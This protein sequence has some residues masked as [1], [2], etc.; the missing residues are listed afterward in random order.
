MAK[1]KIIAGLTAF[2]CCAGMAAG[3]PEMSVKTYAS[4]V[5]HNSFESNYDG[6]YG[7]SDTV[8]ITAENG[9]GYK[10]SRGMTVKGRVSAEDG[11]AS[12]KGFYLEGGINYNYS[13]MVYSKKTENFRVSL[14]CIDEK[15][16]KEKN[17][18]LIS[19][20]V[21]AGE[22]TELSTEYT[23][24]KGSY[25][26]KITIT[27]DSTNDFS[28]DDVIITTEKNMN[29][30]Y[31][32]SSEKGLKDEFA[33][34]FRVGN[35][36][37]NMT[38]KNSAIT[39]NIIKD[40][41]SI[42][43]E[44]ETKPDA[45]LVQSQCSG[46]NIGVSLQ[47]AAA[48][49]DFCVQNN[50]A[51]RGHTLVWHSQTPTWFF[52]KDFNANSNW[53]D[54][55]TMDAR[56]ESYIKNMFNA[57]KTQYPD[58]NLYAYDVANE[59]VSDDSRRTANNGG[60]REPGDGKVTGGKSAWVQ[61]YGDNSFVEKAFTYARKYAPEGCALY[62]NDYNEYWDHKR[63]AIYNMCKSLYQKGLLDG[64]GMQ[65]HVPANATGF[66]G[67]DSYIYAMK[68]YLS[69]GCD[70]QITE[71]DISLDKGKYSLQDQANKYKAIFQAAM[72]WNANPQSTGRVTAVCVW[73]PNDAN[74]WLSSGSD[75]LL[76]D[77]NN[78]PKLAYKTLTS[79]IP[80]SEWGEGGSVGG[81][82]EPDEN[83]YYFHSTFE[84]DVDT[85]AGRGNAD[86][87]TSGRTA[88]AGKEALLVE[89]RTSAWNGTTRSLNAR[90]FIPGNEYS[91]SVNVSYFDGEST[92]KF[93]LKLQ[94]ED[95]DGET[96]YSTIAEGTGIAGEW[97]QLANTNYKIPS[98]ASKMQLYVETAETT[99]NFYIDEAIG[100]VAGTVIKGAGQSTDII[101]GDIT[102]DN[103]IDC[104]DIVLAR[105]GLIS[106]FASARQKIAADVDRSGMIEIND[107]LLMRKFVLRQITE[108]PDNTPI[109]NNTA[110]K[111][112][113]A[114]TYSEAP[115]EYMNV[116]SQ[117][118]TIKKETYNG[119][120]GNNNLNVYLPYGYD[121]N[122]Q[123]NIFYLMH[124]GGENENTIF[125]DD[126]KLNNILD[127][128]IMNGELEPMIVVTPTFNKCEARTFYKEFRESVIPFV[129]GKYSTYAKST[130][131]AD[132]ADSRMHRAYGG[133]SMGSAS[134]WAVLVNSLDIVGYFM[135]L[136]GDNWE[137][138]GGYNKAKSVADA[139]DKSGL[140]K[141]EYFI[142][143][144][145]GSDDIA[146]PN[147]NPQIE[148]MKK[149]DQ[150][151]YTSDFSKGNF[152]YLVADGKTHWWGYVRH[153][154]YDA[155]PY[156]FHE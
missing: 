38:I 98:D 8:K 139:V 107:V 76:Y 40:Y 126:V 33:A 125:S 121:D 118:G 94:Y 17:V 151:V 104:F 34:Y 149:M 119:I 36:L 45:T 13:V 93:Y 59:C 73:G 28:F 148:E 127:H 96:Q 3:L 61:I 50:I 129:E 88:Y 82:I 109:T 101:L 120:N 72:D 85:W 116:C 10:D 41:N 14:L 69:I 102:D 123:Y 81:T 122:K 49:M 44:N 56:M 55:S 11:A 74:S 58:L 60:A 146:Y 86:V 95:A 4:E 2:I 1:N 31:A 52:K 57:I 19:E 84:S 150:F 155:L 71:L 22:W 83:G 103:V 105:R 21:K 77:K 39:A 68:K 113:S 79:M 144:A 140:N 70:V 20:N 43:C 62:Y 90:A 115:R 48:I 132:I 30:V 147:M 32:A 141:D 15:T 51:M 99:N 156:F 110:F 143:A 63:D 29:A 108:F 78:Q 66:A 65:S 106:G 142:F 35:I 124:G 42:E 23:A 138:E 6:W 24:P 80:E 89:N 97:I 154:I 133:F 111:Y 12:S 16:N 136:S 92:D 153:Y 46:T 47:S 53:V 27:T 91:F 54:K 75:A 130:S 18:E 64:V 9:T 117:A 5:V 135:P 145:T 152:Y 114:L 67:T 7:N 134:T 87:L 128:M 37:N 131:A 100:A 26:F 137:A 25:E 112:N